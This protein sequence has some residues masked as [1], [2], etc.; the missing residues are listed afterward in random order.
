M[1]FY[2]LSQLNNGPGD[3][4]L[5]FAIHLAKNNDTGAKALATREL[6]PE[7]NSW[8]NNHQVIFCSMSFWDA[9]REDVYSSVSPANSTEGDQTS[10]SFSV[11]VKQICS[12]SE[13]TSY[14]LAVDNIVLEERK[15]EWVVTKWG[16]FG[17]N[18]S[19]TGC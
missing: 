18:Y 5:V 14:C 3:V 9:L 13:A 6:W 1:T 4:A 7:I 10:I 11:L 8:V 15:G 19:R 17:E 12:D 16:E 2:R